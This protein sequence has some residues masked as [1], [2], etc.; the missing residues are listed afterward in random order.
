MRKNWYRIAGLVTL[1]ALIGLVVAQATSTVPVVVTDY[2]TWYQNQT[3]LFA[4]VALIVPWVTKFFTA[5]GKDWF[6]TSGRATQWLSAGMA[7][8]LGGIGGWFS[9]GFLAG[10]GG[11]HAALQ[12][13]FLTLIAFLGSNGLAKAARQEA[14]SGALR[15]ATQADTQKA[16]VVTN[17]QEQA[18]KA[19]EAAQKA[20][21][22][23]QAAA[24]AAKS[25]KGDVPA[26]PAS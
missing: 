11:W 7:V 22:A 26:P 14:A 8:L 2:H 4:A 20:A 25:I 15:A 6:K 1:F 23:A 21:A 3:T 16:A 10:S 9:L 24:D 18:A 17:A 5:I 12:A 19:A 13:A